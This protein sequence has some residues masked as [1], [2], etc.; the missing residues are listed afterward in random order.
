MTTENEADESEDTF[1]LHWQGP[2][3]RRA[4]FEEDEDGG[5]HRGWLYL[6]EWRDDEQGGILVAVPV[7]TEIGTR[8]Q[9]MS[10]AARF[11]WDEDGLGGVLHVGALSVPLRAAA[12]AA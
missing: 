4:V 12:Q 5:K 7:Y 1:Q 9:T 11:E 6:A 10:E 3:S 2:G 8:A